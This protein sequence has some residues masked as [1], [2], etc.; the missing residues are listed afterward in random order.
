MNHRGL[1]I[2]FSSSFTVLLFLHLMPFPMI[3]VSLFQLVEFDHLIKAALPKAVNIYVQ[4]FE[5]YDGSVGSAQSKG[6]YKLKNDLLLLFKNLNRMQHMQI[7]NY[8]KKKTEEKYIFPIRLMNAAKPDM[9][10]CGGGDDNEK[11]KPKKNT[12]QMVKSFEDYSDESKDKKVQGKTGGEE[13]E[14]KQE[15][16]QPQQ[17]FGE[18]YFDEGEKEEEPEGHD[19]DH[20][21]GQVKD[22]FMYNEKEYK[23]PSYAQTYGCSGPVIDAYIAY[24]AQQI[25]NDS[26]MDACTYV[27]GM[28]VWH[29]CQYYGSTCLQEKHHEERFK[30]HDRLKQKQLQQELDQRDLEAGM[31]GESWEDRNET[32]NAIKEAAEA[33]AQ[34]DEGKAEMEKAN[35]MSKFAAKRK[36]KRL[37]KQEEHDAA[38][39]EK[40]KMKQEK[41]ESQRLFGDAV[42]EKT[43]V[44]K[45]LLGMTADQVKSYHDAKDSRTKLLQMLQLCHEAGKQALH[46]GRE[47]SCWFVGLL[48]CWFVGLLVCWFVGLWLSS[49]CI[50]AH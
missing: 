22:R 19:I 26:F 11:K 40:L 25:I 3:H 13:K 14:E 49:I 31:P 41:A 17:T 35:F 39:L 18:E 34:T 16:K 6:D 21:I 43:D 12:E 38:K 10:H 46:T 23:L 15:G 28:S 50:V 32:E 44:R 24:E 20:G 4:K 48:V 5:K 36:A 33:H 47:G 2:F 30:E 9:V 7:V 8:L 1:T 45:S 42:G 29:T 37:K 27:A